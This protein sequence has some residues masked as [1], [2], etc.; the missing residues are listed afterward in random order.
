MMT[1]EQ[2]FWRHVNKHGPKPSKEALAVHPDLAGSRCWLWIGATRE[3][4]GLLALH[5]QNTSVL[6]HRYSFLLKYGHYPMPQ[7]LHKCDVRPCCNPE[8][9]LE[10]TMKDNMQDAASKGRCHPVRGSKHSKSKLTEKKVLAM[11]SLADSGTQLK[12]LAVKF[13]VDPSVVSRIAARKRWRH[14]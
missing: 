9:I 6:A 1:T 8:H 14:V 3:G 11:R 10:G 12:E 13:K 7:G 5:F 2:R 4:Y